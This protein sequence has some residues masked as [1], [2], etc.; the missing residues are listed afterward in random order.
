MYA[1]CEGVI[2]A[3]F[4]PHNFRYCQTKHGIKIHTAI[5]GITNVQNILKATENQSRRRR[6]N[7]EP[8]KK[9]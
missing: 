6:E 2:I 1:P 9:K 5:L 4:T 3:Y 8:T 7:N